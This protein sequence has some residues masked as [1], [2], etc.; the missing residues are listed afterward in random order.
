MNLKPPNFHDLSQQEKIYCLN[1]NHHL[2]GLNNINDIFYWIDA[3]GFDFWLDNDDK[4]NANSFIPIYSVSH[5]IKAIFDRYPNHDK[6]SRKLIYKD[7][8]KFKYDV[9]RYLSQDVL[10]DKEFI[11]SCFNKCNYT[12]FELYNHLSKRLKK[13]MDICSLV[14]EKQYYTI[15]LNSKIKTMKDWEDYVKRHA[16]QSYGSLNVIVD[17]AKSLDFVLSSNH[18]IVEFFRIINQYEVRSLLDDMSDPHVSDHCIRELLVDLGQK[19]NLINMFWQTDLGKEIE[20][21]NITSYN[22]YTIFD[23]IWVPKIYPVLLRL[24]NFDNL[25][26]RLQNIHI[27]NNQAQVDARYSRKI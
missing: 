11:L 15:V 19:N 2:S 23:S 25:D 6:Y 9:F 20:D 4:I 5:V 7:Y 27:S 10:D 17:K 22:S 21:F 1:Q 14:E 24:M 3:C 8:I 18:S 13:D 26:K 16:N 12:G